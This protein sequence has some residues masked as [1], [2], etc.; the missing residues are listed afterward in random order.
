MAPL[1]K[2]KRSK[3]RQGHRASHFAVR[4]ISLSTCPQCQSPKAPHIAC[5]VCGTYNGRQV[6]KVKVQAE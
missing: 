1:P 5:R 4:T 6:L 2:R 3:S